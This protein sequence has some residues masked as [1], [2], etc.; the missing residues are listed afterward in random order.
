MDLSMEGGGLGRAS[1]G[2]VLGALETLQTT[3]LERFCGWHVE[4]GIKQVWEVWE[5]WRM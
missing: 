3:N 5:V 4:E 1:D 2:I